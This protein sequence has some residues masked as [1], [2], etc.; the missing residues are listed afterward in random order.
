MLKA[1]N[2]FPHWLPGVYS[3]GRKLDTSSWG[4]RLTDIG[5]HLR[6]GTSQ[7]GQDPQKGKQS[8]GIIRGTLSRE[9]EQNKLRPC[10]VN[11][12]KKKKKEGKK[13]KG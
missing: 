9:G 12:I 4:I 2:S 8:A 6:I 3:Q 5:G 11:K 13:Y 10:W 1:P 7:Q